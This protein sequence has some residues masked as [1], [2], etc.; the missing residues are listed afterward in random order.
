MDAPSRNRPSLEIKTDYAGPVETHLR[1]IQPSTPGYDVSMRQHERAMVERLD[2]R[3]GLSRS[4]SP[5][6]EQSMSARVNLL[7][8][9][10]PMRSRTPVFPPTAPNTPMLASPSTHRR[11]SMA[12]EAR[13]ILLS[14]MSPSQASSVGAV[15]N[16]KLSAPAE[17]IQKQQRPT[18]ALLDPGMLHAWGHVYLGD[19][20][21]ADVL[22]APAALR[23]LSGTEQ[24][25]S[26]G[27]RNGH[28]DRIAIRARV[29]PKGRERKPFL[30][31]RS[32]DMS[33]L[34]AVVT[35]A[36]TPVRSPRRQAVAPLSPDTVSS[37]RLPASPLAASRRRSSVTSSSPLSSRA[38]HQQRGG[39]R[40][41][42]IHLP[43]ART[44]LPALAA[45][46]LSGHVKTGDTIDLPM[47]HPEAWTQ[48]VA[49][50]YTGRGEL[51]EA[52]KQNILH[53][54][55]AV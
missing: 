41:M 22:V 38:S 11:Q 5:V 10:S 24:P 1:P 3:G 9:E 48:T 23:R 31:E 18:M 44:Y 29:R 46:M 54:G 55:G 45:L 28:S 21:K 42:P 52:I 13:S 27:E 2:S 4:L 49:Y 43:Y 17:V 19:L 20:T 12:Q 25:D 39:S 26:A 40:E 51:T 7:T 15:A 53:L 30:I 32:L 36:A 35:S 37:P 6:A 34:R 33:V 8:M 47:P 50:S 16:R 14:G